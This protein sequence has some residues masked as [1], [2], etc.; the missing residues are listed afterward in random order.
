MAQ[1]Q[2]TWPAFWSQFRTMALSAQEDAAKQL[3]LEHFVSR[4]DAE[5]QIE[6]L[7]GAPRQLVMYLAD[8]RV[9]VVSRDSHGRRHTGTIPVLAPVTAN[10]LVGEPE[11]RKRS[12]HKRR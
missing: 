5:T 9:T 1:L 6:V 11:K 12:C 8:K 10:T 2:L 4:L 3:D 7:S